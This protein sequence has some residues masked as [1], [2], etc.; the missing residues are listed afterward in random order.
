MLV[1]KEN[2]GGQI[3]QLVQTPMFITYRK[4]NGR[5]TFELADGLGNNWQ[6]IWYGV[7]NHGLLNRWTSHWAV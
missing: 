5:N 3:G 7:V 4:K 6:Q 1:I 2:L